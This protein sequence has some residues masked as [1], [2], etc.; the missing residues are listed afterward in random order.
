MLPTGV[1]AGMPRK[2]EGA[3]KARGSMDAGTKNQMKLVNALALETQSPFAPDRRARGSGGFFGETIWRGR[4]SG[5]RVSGAPTRQNK[6]PPLSLD[7]R[8]YM[9]TQPFGVCLAGPAFMT[10]RKNGRP[11]ADRLCASSRFFL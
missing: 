7:A 6:F 11:Q 10:K 3:T 5:K 1:G 4:L 9:N 8:A 2:N